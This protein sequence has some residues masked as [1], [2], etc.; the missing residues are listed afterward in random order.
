[1]IRSGLFGIAYGLKGGQTIDVSHALVAAAAIADLS[2][3]GGIGDALPSDIAALRQRLDEHL[4]IEL[5]ELDSPDTKTWRMIKR[6]RPY[7]VPSRAQR[8]AA[9]A[10]ASQEF[11]TP[12]AHSESPLEEFLCSARPELRQDLVELLDHAVAGIQERV[13][14]GSGDSRLL[15]LAAHCELAALRLSPPGTSSPVS[16]Q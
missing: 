15:T 8:E 10:R 7:A 9:A 12:S 11:F 14:N 1:M 4:G 16:G 2:T 3:L 13:A 5:I 6:L